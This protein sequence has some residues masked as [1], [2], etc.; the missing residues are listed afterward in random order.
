[1]NQKL[2]N[3]ILASLLVMAIGS[4]ITFYVSAKTDLALL[5]QRIEQVQ[6]DKRDDEQRD[7]QLRKQWRYLSWMRQNL[8]RLYQLGNHPIPVEPD[9]GD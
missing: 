3:G 4:A 5:N 7:A 1:M 6:T 8:N 2:I 9:L